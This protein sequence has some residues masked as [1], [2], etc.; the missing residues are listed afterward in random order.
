MTPDNQ[1]V[2]TF[3]PRQL[4]VSV[5]MKVHMMLYP[6]HI[7]IDVNKLIHN[8][9]IGYFILWEVVSNPSSE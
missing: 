6:K 8:C 4:Q 1:K 5:L 7:S 9:K 2:A 3:V